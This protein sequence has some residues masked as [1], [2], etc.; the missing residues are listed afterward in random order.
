MISK[1][2]LERLAYFYGMKWRKEKRALVARTI[3]V[4]ML[5]SDKKAEADSR[6]FIRLES[7]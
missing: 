2:Q 4:L 1:R 5:W 7:G 3:S 6:T